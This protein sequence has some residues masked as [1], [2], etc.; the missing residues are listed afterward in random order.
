[1]NS[2]ELDPQS[3][4]IVEVAWSERWQVYRRLQELEIPCWCEVDRPLRVKIDSTTEAIQL[5]SI[6]R[7]LSASPRE[8]TLSLERCWNRS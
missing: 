2:S 3:G 5:A 1:M 8:L 4:E 7:R 6:L